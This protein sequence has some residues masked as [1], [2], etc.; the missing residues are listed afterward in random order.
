MLCVLWTGVQ[1]SHGQLRSRL[2]PGHLGG[3]LPGFVPETQQAEALS[4]W[5]LPQVEDRQLGRGRKE[6]ETPSIT[7]SYQHS[8]HSNYTPHHSRWYGNA[9]KPSCRLPIAALGCISLI[10]TGSDPSQLL[11]VCS[12]MC[13]TSAHGGFPGGRA[14]LERPQTGGI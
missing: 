3:K 9:Q 5:T 11:S 1:V 12:L 14:D 2:W 10:Q 8:I 13:V 7:S 4:R 6:P